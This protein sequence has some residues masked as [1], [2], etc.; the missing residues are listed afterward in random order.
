MDDWFPTFRR[1]AGSKPALGFS[2]RR[3]ATF[4][5]RL[6]LLRLMAVA[7]EEHLPLCPLLDAWEADQ[8]GA[9]G[10]RIRRLSQLLKEGAP[11]PDAVEQVPG[12]LRDEDVLAVRFGA[13]SGTL[14]ASL[15]ESIE[16]L[17]A[18][19]TNVGPN[20]RSTL[21]YGGVI[22]FLFF[23]ISL[24]IYLKIIPSIN[25]IVQDFDLT[26]PRALVWSI[27]F[28][29]VV[30]QFWWL[31]ALALLAL[32]WSAFS[33]RPGRFLRDA[34]FGRLFGSVR[35]LRSAD[36]LQKLSVASKAGRPIPGALS[37]LARY[38]FDPLLRQKLLFAR[39]EVEQGADVWQTLT[40][41]GLLTPPEERLLTIADRVGNRPWA[42][43]QLAAG[44]K[45]RTR[46]WLERLSD[47][48]LPA[49][50][51]ALGTFVLFQGLS[52]FMPLVEIV[53]RQL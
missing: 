26:Q 28:A 32:I 2:W 49:L 20:I 22:A 53:T 42:L 30:E 23:L 50:A 19:S 8:G 35:E 36:V 44:K 27:R 6:A 16:E 13:Q 31:G 47:L 41:A 21:F 33:A 4:S 37:T 12:V 11:L 1:L 18:Q 34:V 48:A 29:M 3:R 52:L 7:T 5:Q 46:R 38:H 10:H 15:R 39:N 14:A 9:Q 40:H 24:F 17:S 51:L 43:K 45:R 25:A